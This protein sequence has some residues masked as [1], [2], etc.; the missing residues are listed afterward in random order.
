LSVNIT[1]FNPSL[2]DNVFFAAVMVDGNNA[3]VG[4]GIILSPLNATN[5]LGEPHTV[6]AHVQNDRGVPIARR[7]VKFVVTDGPNAGKMLINT[8]DTNGDTEYTYTGWST[9]R[10]S[11]V[12]TM[13]NTLN[14]TVQ[15]NV[16]F[17]QWESS[18]IGDLTLVLYPG[19]NFVSVPKTLSNGFDTAQIF[20]NVDTDGHSLWGYDASGRRW[21]AFTS[22]TKVKVLDG[23]WIYS[24]KL[25]EVPLFLST[26][27]LVTPPLKMCY[28]GWNA[29]GFSDV[30]KTPARSTL[31]SVKNDWSQAIGF[32][33]EGQ[34]YEVSIING[35][36]GIH[37]ELKTLNPMKGYWLYMLDNS[38]LA[39]I[40]A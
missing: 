9:G 37:S 29:I 4:E 30:V 27:P 15:S 22:T 18:N 26:D 3:I 32:D 21:F 28:K 12:A 20:Q 25:D 33:A 19:W 6:F 5:Y 39:A 40:S 31:L 17:K 2:D 8:T 24:K 16:V 10:D 13:N 1:T 14:V 34:T 23:F 11:I 7:P 35:A 38:E 36:T